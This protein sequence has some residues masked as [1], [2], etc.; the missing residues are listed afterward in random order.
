MSVDHFWNEVTEHFQS[1][2][3]KAETLGKKDLK[4]LAD[5][6]EILSYLKGLDGEDMMLLIDHARKI[7]KRKNPIVKPINS[8]FY[9]KQIIDMLKKLDV[10]GL[11][12]QGYGGKGKSY[13]L[14]GM[15]AEE[16]ARV[17]VSTCTFFGAHGQLATGWSAFV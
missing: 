15:L 10:C 8:D 13:L 3:Q 16:I 11:T 5:I 9:N 6:P 7:K 1:A 4:A 2:L 12:Y 14:E 17:D